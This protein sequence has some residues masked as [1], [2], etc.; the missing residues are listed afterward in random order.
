MSRNIV[1]F[2]DQ[3]GYSN[4]DRDEYQ[5]HSISNIIYHYDKKYFLYLR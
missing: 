5:L 4:L 1:I 2:P 3:E